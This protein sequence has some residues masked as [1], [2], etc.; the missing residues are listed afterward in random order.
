MTINDLLI[1]VYFLIEDVVVFGT[2]LSLWFVFV[3]AFKSSFVL[4]SDF[5]EWWM[6]FHLLKTLKVFFKGHS[7]KLSLKP[8]LICQLTPSCFRGR[9]WSAMRNHTFDFASAGHMIIDIESRVHIIDS[10]GE[11]FLNFATTIAMIWTL[12]KIVLVDFVTS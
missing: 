7:L 1:V 10:L 3:S 2:L 6:I 11:L 4:G 9:N 5:T 12:R 8:F